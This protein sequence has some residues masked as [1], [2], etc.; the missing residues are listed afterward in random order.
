MKAITYYRVSSQ[1]QAEKQSIDLQKNRIEQFSKEQEYKVVDEFQDDGISGETIDS[2]PDFQKAL[3]RIEKGDVDVFL[4]YMVDRIGR[5]ASRKDR[6]QVIE[7]I[8]ATK[9]SVHSWDDGLFRW[10]N[11]KELNDLEGQLND[12][13]LENVKRGKRISEGH[14]TKR[15]KGRYSG[16]LLPYG[17]KFEKKPGTFHEVPKEVDTLEI[18]LQKIT[19]GWGLGRVRDYLNDNPDL[20]PKRS[21]KFRG[22]EVTKWSAEHVRLLILND[23]YFTGVVPLTEKSKAK[24]IPPMDTGIKLFDEDRVK[25]ARREMSTRRVRFIDASHQGR[26]RIHSQKDKTVFTDA[27]LHGIVRCGKCGWRLGIQ[28]IK[29]DKYNYLY[30][31]CRGRYKAKCD[32]KN[33][34]ADVLDRNVWR[35]F[36]KTLSNPHDVEEMILDQNFIIDKNLEEK[37][38]EYRKAEE[39][40][41]KITDTIERTKKMYQW[42]HLTDDKYTTEIAKLQ[43][44]RNQA[45]E[46]YKNLGRIINQ[47]KDVKESVEQAAVYL[48]TQL[49]DYWY[50]E[51]MKEDDQ[52]EYGLAESALAHASKTGNPWEEELRAHFK[53]L[54][55]LKKYNESLEE[56]WE[57]LDNIEKNGKAPTA[58]EL[59]NKDIWQLTFQ[60][61]RLMLQQFNDHSDNKSIRVFDANTFDLNLYLHLD[62]FDNLGDK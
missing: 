45:E 9:T 48:A 59:N 57:I 15:L 21:R 6:N 35:E 28:R 39:D 12:S 16:G 61:K 10:D 26:K 43:W 60:Q 30:Y 29:N 50:L 11:E 4:V 41:K 62:L 1:Q 32:L 19:A 18:I 14:T 24:K 34:R 27:L 36:I 13:R 52:R 55:D 23:F 3:Q 42:G 8:E 53:Q 25:I 22:K 46:M 49:V 17:V 44:L 37:K 40:L 54:D 2:R 20:Y 33:V 5:F 38:A 58:D 47:P 56:S 31:A 7:L 51:D